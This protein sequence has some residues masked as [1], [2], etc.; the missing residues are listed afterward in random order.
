MNKPEKI[1]LESYET[2][3]LMEI[4]PVTFVQVVGASTDP[5]SS[6]GD[7]PVDDGDL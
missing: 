1:E 5:D 6:G 4:A 2:P 3:A 7:D